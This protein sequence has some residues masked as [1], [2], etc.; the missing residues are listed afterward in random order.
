MGHRHVVGPVITDIVIVPAGVCGLAA[1]ALT[2]NTL[3]VQ[4]CFVPAAADLFA[5]GASVLPDSG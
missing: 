1:R 3:K 5:Y 4:V 2:Y